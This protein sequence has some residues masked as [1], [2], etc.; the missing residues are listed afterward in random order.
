[1]KVTDNQG[2]FT[3]ATVTVPINCTTHKPVISPT[4]ASVARRSGLL[5]HGFH[6][7]S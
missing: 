5:D 7:G 2:G 6:R 1:M 3:T 4:A